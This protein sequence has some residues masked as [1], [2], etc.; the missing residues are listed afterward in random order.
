MEKNKCANKCVDVV[1]KTREKLLS[2]ESAKMLA[3]NFEEEA[4]KALET[5][6]S[7][8]PN[9][10]F[11]V[12]FEFS[13]DYNRF[14][15]INH[16]CPVTGIFAFDVV[17]KKEPLNLENPQIMYP[18]SEQAEEV[19]NGIKTRSM[20]PFLSELQNRG[21]NIGYSDFSL[22]LLIYITVD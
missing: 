11:N 21:Y 7:D 2:E 18:D 14:D 6:F 17:E 19:E 12:Y 3:D 16:K 15:I 1:L 5:F 20:K 10:P 9:A 13:I 22:E 4:V 8:N